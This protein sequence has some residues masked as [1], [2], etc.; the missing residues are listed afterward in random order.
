MLRCINLYAG[1]P[2]P[3]R[4]YGVK[5]TLYGMRRGWKCTWFL[6]FW[7]CIFTFFSPRL[8]NARNARYDCT[9]MSM[10]SYDC[11]YW[12]QHDPEWTDEAEVG[13][14]HKAEEDIKVHGRFFERDSFP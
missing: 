11:P 2:N 9:G 8:G 3:S 7:K 12:E 13:A 5:I 4:H 10:E 1:I 14:K 6:G